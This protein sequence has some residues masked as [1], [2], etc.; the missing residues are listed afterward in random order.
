MIDFNAASNFDPADETASM[1]IAP[2]DAARNQLIRFRAG[3]SA[4][5]REAT[6]IVVADAATEARC[7]EMTAQVKTLAKQIDAQQDEIIGKA[8]KFVRGVQGITLPFR[9]DL[10][11]IEAQLKRKLGDYAYRK[12]MD[13]RKAEAVAQKAAAEAQ[14]KIDREAKKAGVEP[15][16]LPAPV[17]PQ[18]TAPTRTESGT[19]SYVPVWDFEVED[20]SKVPAKYLV[21]D[22]AS[23]M[24]AIKAGLRDI[25]GLKIVERVQVRTRTA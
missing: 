11:A 22:R 23:V 13:R 24:A 12:E 15:V 7:S 5:Q 9:K 21:V 20:V 1:E 6:E 17:V 2:L 14:R 4:M 16:Q 3:V 18:E 19:T 25:P 10:E 8:Q